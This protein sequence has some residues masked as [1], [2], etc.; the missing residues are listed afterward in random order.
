LKRMATRMTETPNRAAST[1]IIRTVTLVLVAR[2]LQATKT[3]IRRL[4]AFRVREM[5]VVSGG[6]RR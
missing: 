1:I 3:V 5:V 4:A 2:G 6:V